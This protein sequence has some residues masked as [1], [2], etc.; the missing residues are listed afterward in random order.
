MGLPGMQRARPTH[1]IVA[2]EA[3]PN[4]VFIL[5]RPNAK[6]IKDAESDKEVRQDAS[7][8]EYVE[9]TPDQ[10]L[11][12]A[13]DGRRF[14]GS[15]WH[16]VLFIV[17]RTVAARYPAALDLAKAILANEVSSATQ[18][19]LPFREDVPEWQSQEIT[20]THRVRRVANSENL[21]VIRTTWDQGYQ[22]CVVA[23]LCP[24]ATVLGGL[25][26]IRRWRRKMVPGP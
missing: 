20:V 7:E 13:L 2:S 11:V 14:G 17:P 21:E 6:Y 26:L 10:P 5:Y 16:A 4:H 3:F 25:W 19:E 9:V 1:R 18:Y 22:C 8:A 12:V 15:G 24:I 23:L